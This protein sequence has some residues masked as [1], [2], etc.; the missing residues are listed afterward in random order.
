MRILNFNFC[1]T[2]RTDN[3]WTRI[4][5][6]LDPGTNFILNLKPNTSYDILVAAYNVAGLTLTNYE[7]T[8]MPGYDGMY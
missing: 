7:V 1:F 8:T 3:I 5:N 6:K 2:R 4:R